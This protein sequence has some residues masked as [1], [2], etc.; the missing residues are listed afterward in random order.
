MFMDDNFKYNTAKRK[1]PNF[2]QISKASISLVESRAIYNQL[3]PVWV[4]IFQF[5]KLLITSH[6]DDPNNLSLAH[7]PHH[8][9]TIIALRWQISVPQRILITTRRKT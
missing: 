9:L 5:H 6:D 3:P 8:P 2:Q 7:Q 1:Q 4:P